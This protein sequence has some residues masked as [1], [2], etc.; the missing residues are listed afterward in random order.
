M[1]EIEKKMAIKQVP[2]MKLESRDIN[3]TSVHNGSLFI[4]LMTVH[5]VKQYTD[6]PASLAK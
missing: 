3:K 1:I 5:K 4:T 6:A 2:G